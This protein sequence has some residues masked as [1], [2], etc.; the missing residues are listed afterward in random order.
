MKIREIAW[1]NI[2]RNKRR[3][4]LSVAAIAI[5]SMSIVLLFGLIDWFKT[6]MRDNL[7]RFFTGQIRVRHV[8]FDKYEHLSPLHLKIEN[9]NKLVEKI[10]KIDGVKAAAAR[11]AFPAMV[12]QNDELTA[13]YGKAIDMDREKNIAKLQESIIEGRLP[14][15]GKKEIA[16]GPVL[17]KNLAK[18]VGDKITLLARTASYASNAMTFTITGIIKPAF[19]G[20]EKGFFIP[21]DTGQYFLRMRKPTDTAYKGASEIIILL[22]EKIKEDSIIPEIENLIKQGE[23][24]SVK[25]T[26]W[27]DIPTLYSIIG[28]AEQVYN[29]IGILFLVLGST[30]IINT[31]MM[32]IYERMKE[33][34]TMS[35][36]GM[37]GKQ[38]VRL[39]FAEAFYLAII[40]SVIGVALG[41]IASIP[42]SSYGIDY[43]EVF[44]G[45]DWPIS[46]IIYIT[47]NTKT[48][49]QVFVFSVAVASLAS[50]F[51][52]RKAAKLDPI[53][54]LRTI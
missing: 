40:G 14:Q 41:A 12:K 53:H 11:I 45:M 5:A 17:A 54:A 28:M 49:I 29:F 37:E 33:I 15:S 43:S 39:F 20:M 6:D 50:F 35:A 30:V 4:V 22:K 21:L 32:V 23:Y 52:S 13:T 25:A 36:L 1:R 10:E 34:G 9:A 31:T 19:S 44:A 8:D 38:L 16:I 18:K 24:G 7:F 42:L 46:T 2:F 3:S 48:Y 27:E 51:P 26:K 47:P